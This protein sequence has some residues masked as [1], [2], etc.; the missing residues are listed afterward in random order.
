MTAYT[1]ALS[2]DNEASVWIAESDTIP[3]TLE[4]SSLDV[5]IERVKIAAPKLLE[6]NGKE[7]TNI[8]LNFKMERQAIAAHS[9]L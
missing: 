1:V 3:L 4:S 8:T 6:L 7:H 5:L 9:K 2:W